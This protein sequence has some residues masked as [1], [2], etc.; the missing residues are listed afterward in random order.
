[1][2]YSGV[3]M[4][5]LEI[6]GRRYISSARAAKEHKYHADYIGQLVRGGKVAGQ[7]VGRSWYVD[8]DSLSEYLGKEVPARG[9][10]KKAKAEVMEVREAAKESSE[11]SLNSV[12]VSATDLAPEPSQVQV[13]AS[14]FKE[15][16]SEVTDTFSAPDEVELEPKKEE[17]DFLIPLRKSGRQH[18][19]AA[20]ET[21]PKKEEII[22][23]KKEVYTEPV[24]EEVTP[25]I[26]FTEELI[27]EESTFTEEVESNTAEE[28][29]IPVKISKPVQEPEDS[30]YKV[31]SKGLRYISGS[32]T[33]SPAVKKS[34]EITT[35]LP[36]IESKP[37]AKVTKMRA[38][39]SAASFATAASFILVAGIVS[40]GAGV[41][42][43]FYLHSVITVEGSGQ[44]S[45][46]IQATN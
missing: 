1:M 35:A 6:S 9:P 4:D 22:E 20:L 28:T 32:K 41:L 27:P 10:A 15:E 39:T 25:S 31:S 21:E 17:S 8:A 45:T 19:I 29:F 43:S 42:V 23:E 3:Y 40:L 13:L 36:K 34:A 24:V 33:T 5:E 30:F 2:L 46:A 11:D 38:H 18:V 7:K 44:V 37:S 14:D 16:E 26:G 12:V